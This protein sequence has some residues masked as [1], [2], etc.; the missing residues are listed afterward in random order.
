MCVRQ[1]Y[2]IGNCKTFWNT[3]IY[4]SPRF[5]RFCVL[6]YRFSTFCSLL[7]LLVAWKNWFSQLGAVFFFFGGGAD[8]MKH[9][10]RWVLRLPKWHDD[11]RRCCAYGRILCSF[12]FHKSNDWNHTCSYI[13]QFVS[14]Q[15]LRF[16]K[17]LGPRSSN[18]LR[19]DSNLQ[20]SFEDLYV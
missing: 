1:S 8:L 4:S 9:V 13:F 15:W 3:L 12:H 7:N 14:F 2:D 18:I 19:K 10:E 16:P 11:N 20:Q 17:Y 6:C 5:Q